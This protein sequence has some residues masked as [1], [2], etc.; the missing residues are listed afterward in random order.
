MLLALFTNLYLA[1]TY[2]TFVLFYG[3]ALG[4]HFQLYYLYLS[5]AYFKRFDLGWT[6]SLKK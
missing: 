6:E 1:V 4:R 3:L 2:P 5:A